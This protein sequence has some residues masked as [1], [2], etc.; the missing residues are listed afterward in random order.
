[1]FMSSTPP[2]LTGQRCR[3]RFAPALEYPRRTPVTFTVVDAPQAALPL[4]NPCLRRHR[5]CPR[6]EGTYTFSAV[7]GTEGNYLDEVWKL[8]IGSAYSEG[9]E[10]RVGGEAQG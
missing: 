3:L 10:N 8:G 1:M 5:T 4:E 7:P 2:V 9:H 6:G